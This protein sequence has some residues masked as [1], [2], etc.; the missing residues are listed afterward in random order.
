[1]QSIHYE[2]LL[3]AEYHINSTVYLLHRITLKFYSIHYDNEYGKKGITISLLDI[4]LPVLMGTLFCI[5]KVI[6]LIYSNLFKGILT[7]KETMF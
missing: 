2:V 5:N 4:I 6:I 3:Y 1:M 7:T